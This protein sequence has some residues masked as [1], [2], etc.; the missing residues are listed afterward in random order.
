VTRPSTGVLTHPCIG[1]AVCRTVGRLG[2][3]QVLDAGEGDGWGEA[4]PFD[5]VAD[6]A[7][8]GRAPDRGR[9]GASSSCH[10]ESHMTVR[11]R[12]LLP[13]AILVGQRNWMIVWRT[14]LGGLK[15][16][17]QFFCVLSC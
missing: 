2:R 13:V 11:S 17:L 5:G 6:R 15:R 8:G 10:R 3:D 12:V 16:T 4:A 14:I 7:V 9:G 1:S